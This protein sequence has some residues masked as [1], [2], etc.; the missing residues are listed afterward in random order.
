MSWQDKVRNIAPTIGKALGMV[1]GAQGAV[2][3]AALSALSKAL[4]GKPDATE[5]EVAERV[6]NWKPEDELVLKAAEQKFTLDLIDKAVALEQVDAG[7][8][9]NAR[10]REISTHDTTTRILAFLVIGMLATAL[11]LLNT[12]AIPDSNRDAMNQF[13]GVLYGATGSVLSYYF[14]SSVGSRMKDTVSARIA[15]ARG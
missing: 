5:A 3:G 1:G 10:T 11:I 8:R 9:A 15:Q 14:G 4:L 12:H 13:V 6:A 7:D 2:A